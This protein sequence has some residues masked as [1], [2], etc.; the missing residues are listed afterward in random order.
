[1]PKGRKSKS[2]KPSAPP[3]HFFERELAGETPLSYD[4]ATLLYR[5]SSHLYQRQPWDV[6]AD[7]DLVVMESPDNGQYCYCNVMGARREVLAF[8][9]YLGDEGYRLFHRIATGDDISPGEFVDRL[10]SVYVDIVP[11]DE[12]TP[13]DR[14]W[15]R[16]FGHPTRTNALSPILRASRPG[17]H[18]WYVN[19]DEGRLLVHCLELFL[20]FFDRFLP[21]DP[22]QFWP[23]DNVYP[24]VHWD[25][26]D[27]GVVLRR[28]N[29]IEVHEPPLTVPDLRSQDERRI[30]DARKRDYSVQGVWE[31]D[32]VYGRTPIG[33]AHERKIALHGVLVVD[34][35]TSFIYAIVIRQA[36][37]HTVELAVDA[38]L[39]AIESSKT[40][41]FEIRSCNRETVAGLA[42][43]EEHL[44]ISVVHQ[45]T[46]PAL[47]HAR[48]T[49]LMQMGEPP[50]F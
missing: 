37:E 24:L 36:S 14:Q 1:M 25:R 20:M 18:P 43:L 19:E 27:E 42:R 39:N 30:A 7:S 33:E 6:L 15:L 21:E 47:E 4:T 13:P 38:V 34:A 49:L 16:A 11:R 41:P 8:H 2:T 17:F 28:V 3:S 9:V 35:A 32:T 44:D 50:G 46:V 45:D 29:Q 10:N 26:N 48:N 23:E 12:V 31:V 40:I 5:M 22:D